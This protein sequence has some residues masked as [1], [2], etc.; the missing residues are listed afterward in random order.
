M[1]SM[2]G[3]T[4]DCVECNSYR[5]YKG[6]CDACGTVQEE[7][8]KSNMIENLELYGFKKSF[9]FKKWNYKGLI[10]AKPIK[11]STNMLFKFG[12]KEIIFKSYGSF[13]LV[14]LRIDMILND[15][16]TRR[17]ALIDKVLG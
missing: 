7:W 13:N 6:K 8:Y 2:E 14:K 3:G 4:P 10:I 9:F 1:V 12:D 11:D 17:N 15:K 5:V 16:Q